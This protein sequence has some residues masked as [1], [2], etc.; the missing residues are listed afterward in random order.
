MH[1]CRKWRRLVFSYPRSL[2]LRLFCTHGT[3][4]RKTLDFWPR[5]LPIV[6][7]YGGSSGLDPPTPED[8]N[9]IMAALKLT[10]RVHSISLTITSS[11]LEKLSAIKRPFWR[12]ENLI[13]MSRDEVQ[14][15]LP[16][17]FRWGQR[18]CRLH[19]TRIVIPALVQLRYL[20]MDLIDLQLHEV[21]LPW[22][23]SP[24]LL[25]KTLSNLSQLRSLSL[26]FNSAT[27][28]HR[29]PP[30]DTERIF[31]PVLTRLNFRGSMTYL[32]GIVTSID[33]PFLKDIEI[34]FFENYIFALS[35]LNKFFGGIEIY[36]SHCGAHMLSSEPTISM[37]LTHPRAPTYLKLQVFRKPLHMQMSLMAQICLSSSPFLI[38]DKGIIR[39]MTRPSMD[40]S[41]SRALLLLLNQVTGKQLFH[42][43]ITHLI[44]GRAHFSTQR[45]SVRMCY[46][47][48]C[49]KS[50]YRSLGRVTRF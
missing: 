16:N 10:D 3:P 43:D 2:N 35:E 33:A 26:H 46:Y 42:L 5:A 24:A 17:A 32:E 12:L 22:Y 28:Y 39:T 40:S 8:E 41:H 50:T 6:V 23:F 13:L 21:L 25:M 36:R 20:S 19:S 18:L 49:T 45:R 30:P 15:T 29:V 44:N 11:L 34:T 27:Y 4:V 7:E 9:D 31:I 1:I 38:N 37:S 48:L 47:L 14:L